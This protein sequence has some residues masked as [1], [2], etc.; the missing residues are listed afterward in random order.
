MGVGGRR[1]EVRRDGVGSLW[2]VASGYSAKSFYAKDSRPL[3][4]AAEVFAVAF[5][6]VGVVEQVVQFFAGLH[7][8]HER[9]LRAF[10]RKDGEGG[11]RDDDGDV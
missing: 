7:H 9:L 3:V 4:S 2:R 11:F 5:F 6:E 8:V 1:S 10:G